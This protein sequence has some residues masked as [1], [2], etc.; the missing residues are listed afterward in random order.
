MSSKY[1]ELSK[2]YYEYYYRELKKLILV[3]KYKKK[4][5]MVGAKKIK[6]GFPMFECLDFDLK[7]NT[8]MFCYEK[9]S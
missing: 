1:K 9:C 3:T 8:L 7:S 4:E 2:D 6:I 5:L